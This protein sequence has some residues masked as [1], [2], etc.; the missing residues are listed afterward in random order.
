MRRF[1]RAFAVLAALALVGACGSDD[2]DSG[3]GGGGGGGASGEPI[4]VGYIGDLTGPNTGSEVP[5]LNGIRAGIA[6]VNENG[7]VNGRPIELLVEDSKFDVATGTQAFQRLAP[8]DEMVAMMGL[9]GSSVIS[10]LAPEVDK[11]GIPL[12]GPAATTED[13]LASENFYNLQASLADQG[14]A[15]VKY[16]LE[17][18]PGAKVGTAVI[19]VASG[20]EWEEVIRKEVPANGGTTVGFEKL[21]PGAVEATSQARALKDADVVTVHGN[22]PLAVV[23]VKALN[24]QGTEVPVYA[25]YGSAGETLWEGVG[26]VDTD[27]IFGVNGWSMYYDEGA[28]GRKELQEA[29]ELAGLKESDLGS[30]AG[31]TQGYVAARILAEAMKE[32]GD[33]LTRESLH[34]AL[35]REEGFSTYGFAGDI[36]WSGGAP[37]AGVKQVRIYGW[38]ADKG[39]IVA[40]TDLIGAED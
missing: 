17:Q 24:E 2:G 27:T 29:I 34:E 37:H 3:N 8:K 13:G 21:E 23:L 10:A 39:Q 28:E 38:D 18:Q 6:W 36:N 4:V 25:S 14:A 35:R 20:T 33:D 19:N 22:V 9:N 12:V 30:T 31:F 40:V 15:L 11:L 32:A 26:D 1:I 7:G 5:Y 16:L